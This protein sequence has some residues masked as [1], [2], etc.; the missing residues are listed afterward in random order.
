LADTRVVFSARARRDLRRIDAPARTRI[1]AGIDQYAGTG[2]GDVKRV[3]A[4]C[5]STQPHM[6][7]GAEDVVAAT[8]ELENGAIGGLFAS[9]TTNETPERAAYLIFGTKGTI[10]STSP[11]NPRS[12]ASPIPHFGTVKYAL[13]NP[14]EDL[15]FRDDTDLQKLRHPRFD[16]V[17][18]GVEWPVRVDAG[19][20][21]CR[22][23]GSIT[24]DLRPGRQ[25]VRAMAIG[26]T[27]A[28]ERT[29]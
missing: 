7:N 13:K 23:G 8:L 3:M 19:S 18:R 4:V 29:G 11:E 22:F 15:D 5:K 26:V 24:A 1:V 28:A 27:P 21:P 2:V 20:C 17:P 9:W 14:D 25:T 6:V 10:H 12:A 16:P